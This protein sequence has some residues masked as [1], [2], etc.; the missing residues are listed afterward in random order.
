MLVAVQLSVV[1]L[2]LPAGVRSAAHRSSAPDDHFAPSPD[3]RVKSIATGRAD[4]AGRG[5]HVS[6]VQPPDGA[7][8]AGRR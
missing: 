6:P 2:Y 7:A 1:G 4:E 8:I 3:C 5:L